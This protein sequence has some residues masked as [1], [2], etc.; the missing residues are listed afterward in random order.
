MEIILFWENFLHHINPLPGLHLREGQVRQVPAPLG[1]SLRR[2]AI[3]QGE[4]QFIL[5]TVGVKL[6]ASSTRSLGYKG[7]PIRDEIL[8][9]VDFEEII[10]DVDYLFY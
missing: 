7:W 6:N 4:T 3:P 2:Q 5:I 1:R 10:R 8:G 9:L